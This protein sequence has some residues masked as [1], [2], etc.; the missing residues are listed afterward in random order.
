M[1]KIKEEASYI[2]IRECFTYNKHFMPGDPFPENW[3]KNDYKPN[4]HFAPAK[5]AAT[6]L[7]KAQSELAMHGH[8]D[9]PRTTKEL[10]EALSKYMEIDGE[11]PRKKIWLELMRHEN[12]DSKTGA[13][14][15]RA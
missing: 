3:L 8:G 11:W 9:D 4:K 14:G 15:K 13:K 7:E 12:A 5:Q 10:T 1:A 6:M 2:C